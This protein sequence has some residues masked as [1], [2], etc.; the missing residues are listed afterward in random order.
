MTGKPTR[1]EVVHARLKEAREKGTLGV[2]A[3]TLAMAEYRLHD[4]AKLE[5]SARHLVTAREV[6]KLYEYFKSKT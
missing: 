2:I 5:T 3:A 4:I 1:R 6:S